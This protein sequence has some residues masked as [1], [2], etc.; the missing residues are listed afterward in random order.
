MYA[1]PTR[2]ITCQRHRTSNIFNAYLNI[3]T[4][5]VVCFSDSLNG[6]IGA[7]Q[8]IPLESKLNK[9]N[10]FA[11]NENVHLHINLTDIFPIHPSLTYVWIMDNVRL[12]GENQPDLTRNFTKT[13][14]HKISAVATVNQPGFQDCAGNNYTQSLNGTF[15]TDIILKGNSSQLIYMQ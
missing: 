5:S 7:H 11:T 6:N 14:R 4:S 12:E 3:P 2:R 15:T 13:G 10:T 8:K 1:W 9:S